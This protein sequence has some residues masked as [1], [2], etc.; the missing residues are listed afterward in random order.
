MPCG[1]WPRRPRARSTASKTW[2]AAALDPRAAGCWRGP[3][4]WRRWP[5]TAAR[6]P[7]ACAAW[8][9]RHRRLLRTR[10]HEAGRA[11]A[12]GRPGGHR[13][14]LPRHRAVAEGASAGPCCANAWGEF[15]GPAGRR[16]GR[17]SQWPAGARLR[18]GPRAPP[19][20]RDGQGVVFVTLEDET[21]A[22]NVIVW[23]AVAKGAA[24]GAA[25]LDAAH[26]STA[27]GSARGRG[28]APGGQ[29]LVDHTPLLRGWWRAAATFH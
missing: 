19:A 29:T 27:C 18:P 10:T 11:A 13:R 26:P 22:V 15:S 12:A 6:R 23:P 7:G 28:V 4:R 5:A 20:A 25:G 21:G 14:R 9:P 8:T 16:A 3:M 17:L 1:W 24:P 2:R